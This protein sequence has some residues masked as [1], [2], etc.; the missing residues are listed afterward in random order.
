MGAGHA[1]PP[2]PL[3]ERVNGNPEPASFEFIGRRVAIE[4]FMAVSGAFSRKGRLRILDFGC[5]CGRIT[6]HLPVIF[7]NA[8]V[9]GVDIDAEAVDWCRGHL[10]GVRFDVG[11]GHP[12]SP[13][14]SGSF[15]LVLAVSVFS[16]LPEALQAAWL[17]ELA[18]ITADDGR[19]VASYVSDH[20]AP[21]LLTGDESR[22]LADR[23]FVY[24][25]RNGTQGLPA[26]YQASFQTRDYVAREW[27][28]HF[29]I[30][31]D[32]PRGLNQHQELVVARP[33]RG[34]G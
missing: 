6:R 16:H 23:G 4:V 13:F 2:R 32:H 25:T 30:L 7:P 28:R 15:D 26:F 14:P 33:A 19:F 5:G 29:R 31:A 18:R 3:V 20:F 12:P 21:V 1:L 34:A 22:T 24:H 11:P 17:P 27:G 9:L 10:H 8:D